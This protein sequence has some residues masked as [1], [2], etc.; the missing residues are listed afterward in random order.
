MSS[1]RFVHGKKM[2]PKLE[3]FL[4]KVLEKPL[5]AGR[6]VKRLDADEKVLEL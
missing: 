4:L 1:G 5:K 3:A 6:C 2:V